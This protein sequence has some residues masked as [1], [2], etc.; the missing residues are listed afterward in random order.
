MIPIFGFSLLFSIALCVHVVRTRQEMYWLLIILMLQPLGGIVYL[1]AIV[2]PGIFGSTTARRASAAA[3]AQLDPGRDYREASADLSQAPTVHNQMRLAKA[4]AA[5]GR[6]EE[7]EGLYAQA[8]QGIHAEDPVLLL[9]R[10]QALNE[11]RRYD[12]ALAV[13]DR[14]EQD[15]DGGRTPQATLAYA[16]AFE[17]L[18]RQAEA[19]GAYRTA[20]ERLPGLEAMARLAAF[21]ARTGR[22]AQAKDLIVEMDRH[23]D[24]AA[25]QFRRE[26]RGWRDLAARALA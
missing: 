2:M 6:H 7:A 16:R 22:G 14:L 13:L 9:G 10:A 8:A 17:G 20:V 5:L 18:G 12:E 23:I 3:R 21:L 15:A 11:M 24:R 19:E 26:Y 1:V 25:P 4:A